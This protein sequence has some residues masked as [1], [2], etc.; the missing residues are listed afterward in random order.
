M[1]PVVIKILWLEF[2]DGQLAITDFIEFAIAAHPHIFFAI[3]QHGITNIVYP[4]FCIVNIFQFQWV[5]RK[6]ENPTLR[7]SDIHRIAVIPVGTLKTKNRAI[8]LV[9]DKIFQF[10]IFVGYDSFYKKYINGAISSFQKFSGA[11]QKI[12][13]HTCGSFYFAIFY[14]AHAIAER[15]HPNAPFGIFKNAE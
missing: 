8:W 10:S 3:N 9:F 7:R 15:T 6:F 2:V 13:I 14:N 5:E 12:E 11:S 4:V 1:D